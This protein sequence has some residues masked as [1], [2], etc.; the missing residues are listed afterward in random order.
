[1]TSIDRYAVVGHPVSHS[2]SPRIHQAFAQET[3]QS[4]R[5]DRIE[6]PVD[7]FA[8]TV[9]AFFR[10]G[11][12]GVNVTVPFK[13]EAAEWVD[14]CSDHAAFAGAVNTIVLEEDGSRA[15]HNTDGAGL[16]LDLDRLLR[17]GAAGLRVLLLGAGGAAR[18][19]ARPLMEGLA[20]ELVIANRT[21]AR[22]EALAGKLSQISERP[23]NTLAFD[24][25]KGGF[26]LVINATSAGL[27]DAVPPI[28]P[29]VVQGAFCYDMVY[30]GETAFCRW[31][32]EAGAAAVADGL[33]M[34]VGQAAFAF[35]LWRGERPD[36]GPVLEL[37]EAGS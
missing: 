4:L 19:V 5:Y 3:G 12:R 9:A 22:A 24:E 35:E 37:L 31:S 7:G 21:L 29:S 26:D 2:L 23:V 6:A 14:R 36:V 15:G 28:A 10:E 17:P 34:L 27:D 25:L 1:M 20:R 18:G 32:R 11:G 13:G 16:M 33:G 8:E 30:G